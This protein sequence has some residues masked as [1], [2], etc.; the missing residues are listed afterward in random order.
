[1]KVHSDLLQ[2]RAGK[3]GAASRALRALSF[4]RHAANHSQGGP[5]LFRLFSAQFSFS[6]SPAALAPPH[7][8]RETGS[9]PTASR[10][11]ASRA[12]R[13]GGGWDPAWSTSGTCK[14]P[15]LR[16]GRAERRASLAAPRL[17]LLPLVR[18]RRRRPLLL[19][20]LS[21]LPSLLGG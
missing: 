12:L 18:R 15:L 17:L 20:W 4:V 7:A 2:L 9:S 5:G 6:S 13:E 21:S 16:F 3:I 14:W 1:M 8:P 10:T 11:T 19:R